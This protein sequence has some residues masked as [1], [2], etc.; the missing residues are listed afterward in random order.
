[1][2]RS[3]LAIWVGLA[4]I[5]GSGAIAVQRGVRP[6]IEAQL[7]PTLFV[8]GFCSTSATWDGMI[9]SLQTT[10]Q[11]GIG[12]TR[13][14]FDGATV[15]DKDSGLPSEQVHP[16]E[17]ATRKVFTIDFY[18]GGFALLEVANKEIEYKSLELQQVL[19]DV[20]RITGHNSA[21]LVGHSMGGLVARTYVH[22]RGLAPFGDDVFGVIT[23]DT[24]HQGSEQ[25]AWNLPL[26][27]TPRLSCA[28]APSV[29]KVQMEPSSAFLA[30]LNG[31][32]PPDGVRMTSV[33]SWRGS[34]AQAVGDGVVSYASQSLPLVPGYGSLSNVFNFDNPISGL[35]LLLHV[36]ILDYVDTA[37]LVHDLIALS[38]P[39]IGR[40][41]NLAANVVGS[42]V[43]LTWARSP[44]GG[45]P[46]S[47]LIEVGSAPGLTDPASFD[48][49]NAATALDVPDVPNGT[50]VVRVRAQGVAG[51]SSG[52]SNELI[53]TIS[54]AAGAT[55]LS[56]KRSGRARTI[57]VSS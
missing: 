39:S 56:P 28:T 47:Y 10:G 34:D 27:L 50:Y 33:A 38:Q 4:L 41:R 40:P 57:G 42:T 26:P 12:I 31:A 36:R 51:D 49:G 30:G 23:V 14:Y 15:R 3:L 16:S 46:T 20:R 54:T 13:L 6:A 9:G 25:T 53:V 7:A 45:Q 1:M 35:D 29:N 8:H 24:P 21:V 43:A 37:R 2:R 5:T 18:N 55:G 44:V 48:T 52:P 19:N 17:D 11:Y 22:T 32:P